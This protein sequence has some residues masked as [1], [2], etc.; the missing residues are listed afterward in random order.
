[1]KPLA[2]LAAL[3]LA[4]IAMIA[5]RRPRREYRLRPDLWEPGPRGTGHSRRYVEGDD[6]WEV[7]V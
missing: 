2:V 6:G 4:A 7:F 5:M 3:S 1:M